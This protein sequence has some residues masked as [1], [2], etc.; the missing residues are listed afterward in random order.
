MDE[1]IIEKQEY[2]L[3]DKYKLNTNRNI[4]RYEYISNVPLKVSKR[5]PDM[6]VCKCGAHLITL[7][8]IF[9]NNI[10]RSRTLLGR[11]CPCCGHNYFTLKTIALCEEAF[12]IVE[13]TDLEEN[14]G[15]EVQV[16]MYEVKRGDI[17]FADLTGIEHH[18]GSEQT[19]WRPVMIVQN[20][21]GN[22][23][24][25]TTII[26]TITSKIKGSQPTHVYLEIERVWYGV[27]IGRTKS[28]LNENFN[29]FNAFDSEA[30]YKFI[31]ESDNSEDSFASMFGNL[32]FGETVVDHEKKWQRFKRAFNERYT[33]LR[34]ELSEARNMA[35]FYEDSLA[36][37]TDNSKSEEIEKGIITLKMR[38]RACLPRGAFDRYINL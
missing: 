19:G 36:N 3:F 27:P 37:K 17:Y 29:R 32:M 13:Y 24:S 28:N 11:K 9:D 23:Y 22:Y 31:H 4:T 25:T 35:Q 30:A 10:F 16:D 2:L 12:T 7:A 21:V 14:I 8:Y 1:V 20:D 18:C 34:S 38:G 33:E 15:K 26:A 6:R 5:E